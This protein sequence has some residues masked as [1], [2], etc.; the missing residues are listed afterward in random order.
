MGNRI[1]S[2]ND[3][4]AKIDNIAG[5]YILSSSF[6]DML[7]LSSGEYCNKTVLITKSILSTL[8]S[9]QIDEVY[10]QK[11]DTYMFKPGDEI[12]PNKEL[13]CMHIAQFYTLVSHIFS[14]IKKT[15]ILNQTNSTD[16]N[17]NI[18][19]VRK[20]HIAIPDKIYSNPPP[21]P[22]VLDDLLEYNYK[23]D[24]VAVTPEEIFKR[25]ALTLKTDANRK[26]A[27]ETGYG[28]TKKPANANSN[29]NANA[30]SNANTVARSFD[31]AISP[32]P[33][34]KIDGHIKAIEHEVFG[35]QIKLISV[36]NDIFI[37]TSQND[38]SPTYTLNP[39]L[40]LH[41]LEQLA[42]KTRIA[43]STM[44]VGCES[45]FR[46]HLEEDLIA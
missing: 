17:G 32:G 9:I 6:T 35:A 12:M 27:G 3:A 45:I 15:F 21:Q 29:A 46:Q 18:C 10:A 25:E 4:T 11:I 19:Q 20:E 31:D 23:T 38:E 36:L 26:L 40:T 1:S 34:V 5:G 7:Q 37:K 14:G 44:Y 30:N 2:I 24:G 28:H 8:T 13:K 41:K 22:N 16:S 42:M 43:L 33:V 39:R